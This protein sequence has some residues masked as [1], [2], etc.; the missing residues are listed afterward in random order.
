VFYV[1]LIASIDRTDQRYIG[2]TSD[3]RTRMA[4]HNAGRSAHTAKFKPWRLVAYF[5]FVER[6][7]AARFE[8]YL[9]S[10]SGHAFANRHLW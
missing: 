6:S 7:R 3:L 10:G 8:R 1:Y 2:L 4:S 5:A 9:K